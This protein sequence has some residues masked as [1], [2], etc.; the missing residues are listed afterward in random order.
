MLKRTIRSAGFTIVE[1]C[2][3]LA[4]IAMVIAFGAPQV[5]TWIQNL[6]TRSAADSIVGGLQM[7]RLE[8]LKRNTLVAFELTDNNSA[9]WHVCLYDIPTAACTGAD[10]AADPGGSWPNARPGVETT[11]TNFT[12]ALNAGQNV[13][14]LVAFDSFGRIAPASPT[15]IARVDVRNIAMASGDERRLSITVATAGQIRMCDP[16]LSKAT[17]PQGCQ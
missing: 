5:A 3:T 2:I 11:F 10:I 16:Q 6:Q 1:I 4:I 14:S 17:N 12:V 8:A 15:N 7:A 13:P 9:A